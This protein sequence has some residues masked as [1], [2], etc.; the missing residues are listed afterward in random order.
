MGQYFHISE[1]G[2]MKKKRKEKEKQARITCILI[3]FFPTF[4]F[5]FWTSGVIPCHRYHGILLQMGC[6]RSSAGLSVRANT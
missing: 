1:A 2:S 5:A 3:V 4:T 6:S